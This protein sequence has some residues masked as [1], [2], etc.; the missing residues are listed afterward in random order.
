MQTHVLARQ[1][2]ASVV[3]LSRRS[4]RSPDLP[5]ALSSISRAHLLL[6]VFLA[7]FPDPR[8]DRATRHPPRRRISG[9]RHALSRCSPPVVRPHATLDFGE[10]PCALGALLDRPDRL[11]ARGVESMAASLPRR[12][13]RV[14]PLVRQRCRG[15][16]QLP[17]RRHAARGRVS[18]PLPRTGRASAGVGSDPPL[19]ARSP[20]PS[21][22]G[23]VPDL[24]PVWRR[25]AS[26]RRSN[27]A[28]SDRHVRVLPEWS[29]SNLGRLVPSAAAALLP[30]RNCCRHSP[31][32]TRP[33]LHGL[34]ASAP[35]VSAASFS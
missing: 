5:L 26:Q 35:G 11:H 25:Q 4:A 20:L 6:R 24:L 34:S 30:H 27:M 9:R 17:V 29:T 19:P 10:R 28:Q 1:R 18:G 33:R 15:L 23:V 31:H 32:R 16:L 12:L 13:L 8:P 22:L 2:T 21:S 7:E 14:L 3:R